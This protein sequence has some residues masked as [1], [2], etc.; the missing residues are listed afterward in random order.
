ME[1]RRPDYGFKEGLQITARDVRSGQ[2][3]LVALSLGELRATAMPSE[4]LIGEVAERMRN[5]V[6]VRGVGGVGL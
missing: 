5:P 3:W 4:Q 1:K 6:L 2:S